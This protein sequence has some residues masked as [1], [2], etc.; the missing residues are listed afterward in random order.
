MGNIIS[1]TV[2]ALL[3]NLGELR[4]YN[5]QETN[6]VIALAKQLE[7]A[8]D[9]TIE[10]LQAQNRMLKAN[11]DITV[12][13][14]ENF[15][16]NAQTTTQVAVATANTVEIVAEEAQKYTAAVERVRGVAGNVTGVYAAMLSG[17]NPNAPQLPPE[18]SS[19]LQLPSRR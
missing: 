8:V 16:V 14:L 3:G 15:V 13:R 4:L 1:N 12:A 9:P 18:R 19:F 7:E 6:E 10:N 5:R 2:Q 11:A 17:K